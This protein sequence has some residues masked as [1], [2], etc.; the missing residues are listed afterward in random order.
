MQYPDIP[1]MVKPSIWS[2]V[3]FI[4]IVASIG[5]AF[6]AAVTKVEKR[7]ALPA[8]IVVLIW[9]VLTGAV[10]ASG[11]LESKLF[12]PPLIIFIVICLLVPVL[13][14]F[15]RVGTGLV[16]NIPVSFLIGFQCF[17]LP[18]ELVLHQ[19]WKEGIIPVQMTF[20]GYNFDIVSG[21][22]AIVASY[23]AWQGRAPRAVIV[24]FNIVGF[25]LLTAVM[26]IAMLSAPTPFR[27]FMNEPPVLLPFYFPY[28][29]ILPLCVGGALMGH[30]LLF[31]WLWGKRS[32]RVNKG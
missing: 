16:E 28:V 20:A 3:V 27:Q 23:W 7:W 29:W 17:R 18:L 6:I 9:L 14:S 11:L 31:R 4:L 12:P 13:L 32:S 30:L 8:I 15:S 26:T 19:W 10:S 2:A 24:V 22:L 5:F 25:C 21:I 1:A